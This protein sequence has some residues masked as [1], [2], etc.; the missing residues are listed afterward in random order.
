MVGRQLV[1]SFHLVSDLGKEIKPCGKKL[2]PGYALLKLWKIVDL[3]LE[4][5]S[6]AAMKGFMSDENVH[7][8]VKQHSI[9]M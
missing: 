9:I 1:G 7:F 8:S 4:T 5:L 2:L 6:W 3:R